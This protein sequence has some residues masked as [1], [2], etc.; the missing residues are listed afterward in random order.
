MTKLLIIVVLVLGVLAVAQLARVY[1]LTSK[2]R[3]KREEDISAGDNRMN[4]ML[5]WLFPVAYFGFFLWLIYKYGP[6]LLPIAASEHGRSLDKLYD[7]NWVILFAVFFITNILL[8]YFA[9]KYV[10]SRDRKAFYYPHNNKLELLW[11]S[12]PAAFLAVIIIYGLR[13]WNQITEQASPDAVQVELYA[14]QFDWTIRYPGKDGVM[15][16]TDYRL[17][18]G[19][20]PL[21]IVTAQSIETRLGELEEERSDIGKRLDTEILPDDKIDELHDRL[22][23]LDRMRGRITDLRTVMNEDIA[24][25]GEASPYMHGADD[26]VLKEFHLPVHKEVK[27]LIRSQDVIHSAF[28]PHLRVQMNAVPGMTTTFK[29]T[30]TITTDSMRLVTKNENFDFILLCN[31]VCGAS[32]Y[33]MQM[34]LVVEPAEAFATWMAEQEKNPFQPDKSPTQ[35]ASVAVADSSATGSMTTEVVGATE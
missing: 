31:K 9:G 32:H 29:V 3:G 19:T 22:D 8:F 28:I 18:N 20:N 2:L 11:T 35:A 14:K 30:P 12:V 15:G 23:Y 25:K 10:Y 5:M 13:T 6:H 26:L 7:F 17:I 16:A 34:P 27:L 21:G 1:E 33:N 4:A 24:T